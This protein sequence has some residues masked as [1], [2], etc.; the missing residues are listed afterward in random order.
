MHS[1]NILWQ[2]LQ[3]RDGWDIQGQGPQRVIAELGERRGRRMEH[4]AQPSQEESTFTTN[5]IGWFFF[6]PPCLSVHILLGLL[7]Y[8][9]F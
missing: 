9:I 5:L 8:Y 6:L 1:M 7:E 3:C 4:P 2:V